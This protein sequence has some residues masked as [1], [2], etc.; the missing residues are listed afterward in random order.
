MSQDL[1]SQLVPLIR[2]SGMPVAEL[3]RR[4]GVT[5]AAVYR[6]TAGHAIP[7]A[8]HLARLLHVLDARDGV[9][10]STMRCLVDDADA[11]HQRTP[12]CP[13]APTT[14]CGNPRGCPVAGHCLARGA[15]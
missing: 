6:W 12:T 9:W 14:P 5:R 13:H 1:A 2:R 7:R 3:A 15:A 8:D 10:L 4:I 11:L